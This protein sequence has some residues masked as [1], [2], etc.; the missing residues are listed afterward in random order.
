MLGRADDPGL[1]ADRVA[2]A[3]GLDTEK[4]VQ[5]LLTR[6]VG[7]RLR[8]VTRLLVEARAMAELRKKIESEVRK[9]LS[10]ASARCCCASS[11]ARSRRSSAR[12]RSRRRPRQPARAP[13][14]G[15]AAGGGPRRSPTASCAASRACRAPRPST[16]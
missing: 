5:V 12:S 14:Q 2:A 9:G 6:E 15:R 3:L 11:C 13:R 10:S 7:E 4:E 8:L 16:T 1:L